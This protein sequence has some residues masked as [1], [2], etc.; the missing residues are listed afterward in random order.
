MSPQSPNPLTDNDP[1]LP[2]I[3]GAKPHCCGLARWATPA[4]VA[5]TLVA[6]TLAAYFAG[7]SVGDRQLL[8]SATFP[9]PTID[10]SSSQTSE[11]FSIATGAIYGEADAF[12]VLDHNSGLLQCNVLYP[13]AGRFLGQFTV[14]VTEGLGTGG[15]GG[16]YIMVSGRAD[17]IANNANPAGACVIYV[18][19]S[20]S[21]N[22]AV[23]GIPFNRSLVNSSRPQNGTMRLL[24]QGTANPLIDRDNLR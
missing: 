16:K 19:D 23:Y 12:F 22:Y 7:R 2:A 13:R 4:L 8:R 21:G 9:L 14:N 20:V 10:A 1:S 24:H 6:I 11:K 18:M 17:F 5:I 3:D 15:K